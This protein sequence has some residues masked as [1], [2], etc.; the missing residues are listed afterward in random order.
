MALKAY[1]RWYRP[2]MWEVIIDHFSCGMIN[3]VEV[4][5]FEGH[6][7]KGL[8]DNVPI[9]ENV[10]SVDDL[11]KGPKV[12][13][14]K[15]WLAN[16]GKEAFQT[17]HLLVGKSKVWA[18]VFPEKIDLL[19]IDTSH[20]YVSAKRDL[21]LWYPKLHSG[22]LLMCHDAQEDGVNKAIN[23]FERKNKLSFKYDVLGPIGKPEIE[24]AYTVKP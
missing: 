7:V 20:D 5:T 15:K 17:A 16:V 10:Y 12:E 19:Y 21:T 1:N 4:G 13:T 22:G 23:W 2:K 3:V 8:L 14:I 6:W 24:T 9:V 18:K 11:S